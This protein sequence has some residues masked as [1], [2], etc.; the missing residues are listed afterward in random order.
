M[1]SYKKCF[2]I[3]ILDNVLLSIAFLSSKYS[4]LYTLKCRELDSTHFYL[5]RSFT[6]GSKLIRQEEAEFSLLKAPPNVEERLMIHD[7]FLKTLDEK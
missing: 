6:T 7:L 4:E 2:R 3:I 5:F 1:I